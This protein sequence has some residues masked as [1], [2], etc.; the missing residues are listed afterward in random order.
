LE[1]FLEADKVKVVWPTDP[2]NPSFDCLILF[3]KLAVFCQITVR[4]DITQKIKEISEQK[5]LKNTILFWTKWKKG[6]EVKYILIHGKK[7][8]I[9]KNEKTT[10][11]NENFSYDCYP[12]WYLGEEKLCN[13]EA[14]R[15]INE[16]KNEYK[17]N[18]CSNK[19]DD[20]PGTSSSLQGD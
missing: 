12:L 10:V 16:K 1:N 2:R 20:Q 14:M 3:E 6:I 17:D 11:T 4:D 7:L 19:N 8:K 9:K 5:K 13:D 18:T 15:T